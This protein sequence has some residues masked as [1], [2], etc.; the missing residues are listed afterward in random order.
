[1]ITSKGGFALFVLMVLYFSGSAQ[2]PITSDDMAFFK[3]DR[4]HSTDEPGPDRKLFLFSTDSFQPII[5][6]ATALRP[7]DGS[8]PSTITP[9]HLES[10]SLI[11]LNE[12]VVLFD[13]LSDDI[14]EEG[15][16]VLHA[17][18]REL[19]LQPG[20]VVRIEAHTEDVGDPE[21]NRSLSQ[22]QADRIKS[23]LEMHG[24]NPTRLIAVGY[25]GRFPVASN[26]E[27]TGRMKNRRAEF[28]FMIVNDH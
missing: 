6:D 18:A 12:A 21:L 14:P 20:L 17:I 16:C 7:F 9:E 28:R 10:A 5:M 15:L 24:I 25:G 23:E 13:A 3:P 27:R 2:D 22:K 8:D 1:M 11:E 4:D 19:A 26:S